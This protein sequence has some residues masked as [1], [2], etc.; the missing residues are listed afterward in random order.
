MSITICE[1]NE[2]N[3]KIIKL[4]NTILGTII[5]S[6]IGKIVILN[7][8]NQMIMRIYEA[9]GINNELVNMLSI[10]D[11]IIIF[12]KDTKNTYWASVEK[13]KKYGKI[14]QF[15]GYEEQIFLPIKKFKI[16]NV[17]ESDKILNKII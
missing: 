5:D 7:R 1:G 11:K 2:K 8:N 9:W 6:N 16:L 3:L 17:L 4:G 14:K 12:N 15:D 13:I 10:T